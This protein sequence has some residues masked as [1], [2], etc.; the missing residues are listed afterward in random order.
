MNGKINTPFNT[1]DACLEAAE[2]FFNYS[3]AERAI[4]AEVVLLFQE[5]KQHARIF[6]GEFYI[7]FE[8]IDNQ[9]FYTAV[10]A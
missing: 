2:S 1:F 8:I 5:V 6:C 3:D 7:T 9:P 4:P 10:K